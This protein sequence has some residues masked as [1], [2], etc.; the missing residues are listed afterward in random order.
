M[1][2]DNLIFKEFGLRSGVQRRAQPEGRAL[3]P[4][5]LGAV[6]GI[7]FAQLITPPGP[8]SSF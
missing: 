5:S 1:Y 3:N 4:S 2:H 7:G 8:R 6:N